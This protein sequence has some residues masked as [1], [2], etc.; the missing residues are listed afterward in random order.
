MRLPAARPA[1][2]RAARPIND[3]LIDYLGKLPKHASQ[4]E[5]LAAACGD[6]G[7]ATFYMWLE[8]L[9]QCGL[10]QAP[11]RVVEAGKPCRAALER[12]R[13][14]DVFVEAGADLLLCDAGAEETLAALRRLRAGGTALVLVPDLSERAAVQMAYLMTALFGKVAVYAPTLF[15]CNQKFLVGGDYKGGSAKLYDFSMSLFFLVRLEEI[16]TVV[17]QAQMDFM[18]ADL[19]METFSDWRAAYFNLL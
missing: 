8:M 1:A 14:V 3:S 15:A 7:N 19:K 11:L 13:G 5:L 10:P 16:N 17:G 12:M 18:R 2:E 4:Y 6:P 9:Q